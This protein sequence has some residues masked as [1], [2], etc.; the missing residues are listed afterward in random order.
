MGLDPLPGDPSGNTIYVGSA[1]GGVWKTA[2]GGT[3]SAHYVGSANGGVWKTSSGGN[4]YYVGTANGGVWK[5]S[6]GG[7]SY[8]H[9]DLYRNIWINQSEIPAAPSNQGWGPWE[10]NLGPVL[11]G[12]LGAIAGK[13]LTMRPRRPAGPAP[14]SFTADPRPS[15]YSRPGMGILKSQDSGKTWS[16]Y[17]PRAFQIISAGKNA[18]DVHVGN[19][20]LDVTPPATPYFNPYEM[21]VT[22]KLE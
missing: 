14:Y 5:T 9:P 20:I 17:N 4:T 6:D 13:Y 15:G 8:E 1:N 12:R 11:K 22:K 7:T 2:S 10:V 21:T 3:P 16:Y 19:W 18:V